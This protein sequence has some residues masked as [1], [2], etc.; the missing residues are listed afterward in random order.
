MNRKR[1]VCVALPLAAWLCVAAR[2]DDPP[3]VRRIALGSC[4]RQDQPQPI[5]DAIVAAQP[6]VFLFLGDNIYGDSEDVEVLRRKYAQLAAQPGYQRLRETCPVL[7]TWDDHDYG[8]NDG[9]ADYPS[10]RESQQ[11]MLDF[12][13]V[14]ADSPRRRREGVYDAVVLGPRGRRVQVVL[15]DTRYFRSPLAPAR[16]EGYEAD[17][18]RG[19][20]G[21]SDDPSATILGDAQ[22]Q[23]L[24]EQLRQGAELRIVASSIQVVAEEHGY[25]K[26]ANFPRQRQRL[27]D[28]IAATGAGGVVFVSGDRHMAELSAAVDA[29]CGYPLHDLTASSLNQPSPWWNERNRHRLGRAYSDE[30]FG[31]IEI[32]WGPPVPTVSLQVRDVDGRIVIQHRLQ[33]SELQ[34]GAPGR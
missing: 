8:A 2:A 28:L 12:F 15:L 14:P 4:A 22:W 21:P 17:G 5:W 13:G 30:N 9:G 32:D 27:F 24:E 33:T 6:D 18:R 10:K 7:A 25:E 29:P 31:L 11:A 34:Q 20:Y 16:R 26:W 3:T 23:W 1:L 19:P